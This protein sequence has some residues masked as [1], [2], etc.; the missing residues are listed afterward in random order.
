MRE[1]F[2]L[3]YIF[4]YLAQNLLSDRGLWAPL[5]LYMIWKCLGTAFG[6]FSLGSHNF[7]VTALGLLRLVGRT[8]QN[9][10]AGKG[11][12]GRP[13]RFN[14]LLRKPDHLIALHRFVDKEIQ[15]RWLVCF[16]FARSSRF[17]CR[18]NKPSEA[19]TKRKP[20]NEDPFEERVV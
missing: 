10:D 19:H 7:M 3:P 2:G 1:K 15:P 4:L 8:L 12:A 20:K 9:A 5:L 11:G 16:G 13:G 17:H 18:S 14:P 6:H